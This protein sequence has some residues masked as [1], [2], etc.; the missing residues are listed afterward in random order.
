MT[1]DYIIRNNVNIHTSVI[2]IKNTDGYIQQTVI[3]NKTCVGTSAVHESNSD[4]SHILIKHPQFSL[5]INSSLCKRY[6]E[7]FLIMWT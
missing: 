7:N 2:P 5:N 1:M 3:T 6:V 4:L